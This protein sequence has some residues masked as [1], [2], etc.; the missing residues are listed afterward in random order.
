[1]TRR[2][3]RLRRPAA[4]ADPVRRM[5]VDRVELRFS[6]TAETLAARV[7][8]LASA[9]GEPA[10]RFVTRLTLDDLYL[11]T[12]CAADD[13]GAW[14]ECEE[15]HFAFIRMFAR[16]FLPDADARD[17]AD[18]V[19]ADLW[20]RKKI[21]RYGGR[22]T[23][24][25]WLGAVVAHAAVNA[26]RAAGPRPPDASSARTAAAPAAIAPEAATAERQLA[27]LVTRAIAA[28][29]AEEKLL[30]RL[31]YDQGLTLDQ[32]EIATRLSKATLS[33]RLTAL[34]QR[35]RC[36]IDE[37]AG[38][39]FATSGAHAVEGLALNRVEFDLSALLRPNEPVEEE[40]RGRV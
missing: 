18:Q 26:R 14:A 35:L 23:L 27:D 33:R 22:S 9:A 37:R 32:M 29:T 8:E 15:K 34:R 4:P 24:R 36:A 31:Y 5:I 1:M 19:I 30:L 2:V 28:L 40:G 21:G 13:P 25:T 12:A 39:E 6:V 17:L 20:Q 16:R 3:W 11:T 10:A 38:R 7:E